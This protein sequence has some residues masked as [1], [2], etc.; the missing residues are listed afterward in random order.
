[1][2]IKGSLLLL[3]F[4]VGC[5]GLSLRGAQSHREL[6]KTESICLAEK[7]ICSADPTCRN[8]MHT[9]TVP[10]EPT[11]SDCGDLLAW[12]NGISFPNPVVCNH[13]YGF[14]I[15]SNVLYCMFDTYANDAGIACE[16]ST[17]L[18]SLDFHITTA[19]NEES[20][21]ILASTKE[22]EPCD[23]SVS[24]TESFSTTVGTSSTNEDSTTTTGDSYDDSTITDYGTEKVIV[25]EPCDSIESSDYDSSSYTDESISTYFSSEDSVHDSG[26]LEDHASTSYTSSYGLSSYTDRSSSTYFSSEDSV[27]D[28]DLGHPEDATSTSYTSSYGLSSYTDRSSSTYFSSEDSVNDSDL[29]FLD[30]ASTSYTSSYGLS[31]YTDRSSSTYFSSMEGLIEGSNADDTSSDTS[32]DKNS[33]SLVDCDSHPADFDSSSY[34]SA[35]SFGSSTSS[36]FETQDT[37]SSGSLVDK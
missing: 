16:T 27:D 20:N 25:D 26:L 12:W 5:T 7:D 1:M 32:E 14:A 4:S 33:S 21:Q 22:P 13:I 29:D 24:F 10:S 28:S 35:D 9:G 37:Y 15:L 19:T 17:K 2:I 3:F 8:C 36:S 34:Y 11:V 6:G 23:E 30:T 18:V 31:S